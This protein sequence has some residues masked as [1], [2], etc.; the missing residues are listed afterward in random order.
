MFLTWQRCQSLDVPCRMSDLVPSYLRKISRAEKHL[1][2][3]KP[4][5]ADYIESRPYV[6]AKDPGDES[7]LYRIRMTS[8][9]PSDIPLIC[10]DFIYNI[11]SALD[12]LAAALN[13]PSRKRSVYFPI[14]WSGVWEEHS[15]SEDEGKAN[16][17][18]KWAS[19]T[20][21]M[22]PEAVEILKRLQPDYNEVDHSDQRVVHYLDGINLLSNYDKHFEFPAVLAGIGQLRI[23]YTLGGTTLEIN[24]ARDWGMFKEGT[25]LP[26]IP[27]SATNVEMDAKTRIVIRVTHPEGEVQIPDFFDHMLVMIRNRVA[28]PLSPYIHVSK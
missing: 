18:K 28:F 4:I 11:R 1:N 6:L 25:P 17:R 13:P 23:T 9:V 14:F 22:A 26:Q 24:D 7:G 3:L 16:D 2:D 15:E 10:G 12:H 5:I 19:S 20:R 8:N 27:V 21:K